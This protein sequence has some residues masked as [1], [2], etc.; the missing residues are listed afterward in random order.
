MFTNSQ[1]G[2][3]LHCIGLGNILTILSL[4]NDNI[5]INIRTFKCTTLPNYTCAL[6]PGN[7]G[8]IS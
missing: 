3:D 7:A 4:Y 8:Y 5:K 2:E 1:K 6:R